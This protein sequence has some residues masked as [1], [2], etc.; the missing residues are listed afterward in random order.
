MTFPKH[1]GSIDTDVVIVGGGITGAIC[2]YLFANAGI[3][4]ALLEA[5]VVARGSTA[6]STALLM[7]EPDRD[8]VDLSARF[9]RAATRDIWNTLARA[10]R[11]LTRTIRRLRLK[12]DFCEC[13]SVYFTRDPKKLAALRKEFERRKAA[14]L[15]GRWLSPEA[16]FRATGIKA[17]GAIATPHNAQVNPVRA[18]RGFLDA[19]ARRG[20]SIFEGSPVRSVKTS[21]S[22]VEV[23]TSGGVIRA[24]RVIVA[25]GY[26]TPEFRGL[27]GRFRMKDT[28]VIATRRL[29]RRLRLGQTMAWDTDRPYHYLRWTDDG[30]LLV[31][32]EDTNHR[33]VKGARQRIARARGRLMTY[34]T[35][36]Y[37]HLRD[38]RPDYAWEGL[39]AE[40]PDGLPYV[41]SHSRYP[42][43][44]F[45]LGYGGNGMT[46]SFLA[47]R[48][49]LDLYQGRDKGREVQSRAN[50]FAFR[51]GHR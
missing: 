42:K 10:T 38:E 35:G 13:G 47:A 45:A 30:R 11:D 20:A 44:L 3:R 7:Q 12:V 22:V 34:L 18:C 46:A 51:R 49:L 48:L 23:R 1:H 36:I 32:G 14:G 2:A 26:A 25:T 15:A 40:T 39:F 31:G 28:Y 24:A 9:G 37:P 6:A 17:S 19:A 5:K 43:H 29:P 27:V 8:F 4:V 16:L 41:G 21:K 33:S 50:L